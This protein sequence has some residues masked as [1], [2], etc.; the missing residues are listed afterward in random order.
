MKSHFF[1]YIMRMK[2]IKRWGLMKNTEPE[3]IK[4]HSADVAYIA[5]MLA[6][7]GKKIY[8]KD[9]NAE[10]IV[11]F[12]LYHDVSEVITGDLATPIKYFNPEIKEA[13]K[14]IEDISVQKIKQFLP[15]G[16]ESE[17]YALDGK[18]TAYEKQIVKAADKIAAYFKCLDELKSGNSEFSKAKDTLYRQIKELE[19]PEV[20]YFLETFEDS[21]M[22]TLD[23]LS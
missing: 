13:Y 18:M 2:N 23:E 3:N 8:S 6:V 9:V 21:I 17:Y 10:K 12:A 1:A 5:H 19:L 20:D 11:M 16:F 22:L 15:E 14:K 4:E 7:I